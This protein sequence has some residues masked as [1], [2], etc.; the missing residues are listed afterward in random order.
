MN[1]S[2]FEVIQLLARE[3]LY[4]DERRWDAWL[5]LFT[6][7]CLFWL[8]AWLEEDRLGTD[9]E[10]ELSF[11]YLQGITALKERAWRIQSGQ[12]RASRIGH[13]TAHVMGSPVIEGGAT[14]DEAGLVRP[15]VGRRVP[16]SSAAR[17]AW[18]LPDTP[19]RP[20]ISPAVSVSETASRPAPL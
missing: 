12:S 16:A 19:A 2:A 20:V 15:P 6:D 7:D 10:T 18:P 1:A 14:A 8:P 5:A 4:L 17:A 13:R 11:V 9:P 3:A